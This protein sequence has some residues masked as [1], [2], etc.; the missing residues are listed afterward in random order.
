MVTVPV[1]MV[2]GVHRMGE[3][4]YMRVTQATDAGLARLGENVSGKAWQG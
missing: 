1:D 2:R 4:S 3:S